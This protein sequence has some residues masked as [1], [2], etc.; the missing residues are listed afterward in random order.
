VTDLVLDASAY[1]G[2]VA[3]LRDGRILSEGEAVMRGATTENLMPAVADALVR[4]GVAPAQLD[5][6]VCGGGPGSFT[7]LRIAAGIAKGIASAMDIELL[8]V[9]SLALAVASE[10]REP[11]R[12][13]AAMDALRGDVYVALYDVAADGAVAEL[14]A[15]RVLPAAEA[16]LY[17]AANAAALLTVAAAN[18]PAAAWPHA[19][20]VT[21]LAAL[22]EQRRAVDVGA[23]EPAYGRLAEAQVNWEADH[24][25][26]LA[27]A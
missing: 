21:R 15:A 26:P 14:E 18:D 16:P 7:S 27:G 22:I 13:C 10:P 17:A 20:A 1:R 23:W 6:V 3:V 5:R 2:T 4:A 8:S 19:R 25:R 9:P 24:G 12:Y 11:G